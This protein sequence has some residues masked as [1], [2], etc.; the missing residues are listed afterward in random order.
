[1]KDK[2]YAKINLALDVCGIREDGYHLIDS[3]MLP[4]NFYDLLEIKIS[5]RDSYRCNWPYIRYNENHSI[6][7]MIEVLKEKYQIKDHFMID[8]YKSVPIQA[9]LGG[10]TA[11]AASTLRIFQK[12]YDLH[13]SEEEIREICM[14]VG[15]DV[16][17][18]YYNVPARVTGVGDI[19]QEI[20]VKN[21]YHIMLVKPKKGVSTPAAYEMIDQNDCIHPD[22]D[23]LQ[24]ALAE[25]TAID[26]LLGNSLQE[27]AMIL[28]E[29]IKEVID[30]LKEA[31]AKNV[32]MSGS[33]STVFCIS[34]SKQEIMR[35]YKALRNS[36]SY[37]RFG[38]I[39]RK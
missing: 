14:K 31:G 39:L 3:I 8:L 1:M 9:G 29:E 15:A 30:A 25:G 2:A 12:L 17:F 27:V 33:G 20:S 10:G 36:H 24:N 16:L 5:D 7:K 21:D 6:H 28:N 11:D 13:P 22:I 26:G 23:R 37:V 19:L 34:E 18:N 32:L 38:K 4:I 35:L